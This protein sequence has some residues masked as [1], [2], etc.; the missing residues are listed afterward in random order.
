MNSSAGSA[1]EKYQPWII[2]TPA[3]LQDLHLPLGFDPLGNH[4]NVRRMHERTQ[5]CK[6]LRCGRLV[7]Q[8]VHEC[9]RQLDDVDIDAR[10][11][12]QIRVAHANIVQGY[13]HADRPHPV[14][15]IHSDCVRHAP[16]RDFDDDTVEDIHQTCIRDG[17]LEPATTHDLGRHVDGDVNVA[18]RPQPVPELP[19]DRF[20]TQ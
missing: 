15:R 6:V 5:T 17:M 19:R 12:D 2:F 16:L 10:Q 14:Q 9:L 4:L 1:G 13:P 18:M 8:A 20:D 7:E 3:C 11:Y